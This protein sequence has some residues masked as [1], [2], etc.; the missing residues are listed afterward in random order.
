MS[1]LHQI[2]NDESVEVAKIVLEKRMTAQEFEEPK[3]RIK[4]LGGIDLIIPLREG[5]VRIEA[6]EDS[7]VLI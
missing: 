2:F 5:V 7:E 1:K 6:R 3:G 4:S